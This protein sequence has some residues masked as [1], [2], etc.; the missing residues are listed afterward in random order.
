MGELRSHDRYGHLKPTSGAKGAC[1]DGV[2]GAFAD[3][4]TE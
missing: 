3:K 2:F 4:Q 1:Q